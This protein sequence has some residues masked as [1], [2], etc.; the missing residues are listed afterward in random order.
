[1]LLEVKQINTFYGISHILFDVSM[2]IKKGEVVCILGRNGVGKTTTLKSIMGLTPPRSGEI[3]FKGIDITGRRPF[4]IAR[5]GIGYVPEDRI[6]FPDL[7]VKENLEMGIKR[8]KKSRWTFDIVYKM[9]PVL[10]ERENQMGGTLSGGEQQMLAIARTL[11][12]NPELLLLDEPSEG[13]AP[14]IVKELDVQ[15]RHLKEEGMP[16]LLSEQNSSFVMNLSDRAYILEKGQ[17][18]WSGEIRELRE[19]PE[20]MKAYLGI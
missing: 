1:M 3:F 4:E 18:R 11:M 6:I 7:T 16:I 15:V 10:K 20:I 19:R 5:L 12:G 2:E 13:L 8:N 14:L 17:V 9:F